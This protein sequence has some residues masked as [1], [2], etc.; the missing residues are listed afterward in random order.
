MSVPGVSWIEETE[1]KDRGLTRD[2][3]AAP[4][5]TLAIGLTPSSMLECFI[6]DRIAPYC[7]MNCK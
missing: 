5:H 3:S 7:V 6:V 4:I 2:C 1:V